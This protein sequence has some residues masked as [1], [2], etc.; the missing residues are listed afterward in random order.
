[1]AKCTRS[2]E[3][4]SDAADPLLLESKCYTAVL[5]TGMMYTVLLALYFD[6]FVFATWAYDQ[7]LASFLSHKQSHLQRAHAVG[8]L[9]AAGLVYWPHSKWRMSSLIFDWCPNRT[10]SKLD[11][12]CR[13]GIESHLWRKKFTPLTPHFLASAAVF[14]TFRIAAALLAALD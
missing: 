9:I 6:T 2:E 11:D 8:N 4:S 3:L 7:L 14:S 1:M 5:E 12:N 13:G 10:H